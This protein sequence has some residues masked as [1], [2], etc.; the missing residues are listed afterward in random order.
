MKSLTK[1]CIVFF[2]HIIIFLIL[3]NLAPIGNQGNIFMAIIT[4]ISATAYFYF[5]LKSFDEG[6]KVG[7]ASF[8]FISVVCFLFLGFLVML[9]GISG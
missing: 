5:G 3:V 2:V 1:G 9:S 4:L 6:A 8:I 7:G